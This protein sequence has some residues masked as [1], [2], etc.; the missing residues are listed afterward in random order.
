MDVYGSLRRVGCWDLVQRSE[1]VGARIGE[2]G[3]GEEDRM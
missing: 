2:C 1:S 3:E